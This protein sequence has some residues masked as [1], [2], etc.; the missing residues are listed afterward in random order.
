MDYLRN[1]EICGFV[2]TRREN[3]KELS[4]DIL[5][6]YKNIPAEYLS[7]LKQFKQIANKEDTVCFN[8]IED[9]NEETETDFK[10]N[11]FELM[12]LEC[13]ED[14]DEEQGIIR[15]FWNNHIPIVLSVTEYEYLA[16]CLENDRYGEIVHGLEP[17][18]EET[19]KICDNFEQLID[20]MKEPSGNQYLAN[21]V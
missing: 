19:S 14:D 15:N 4:S 18:F 8:S 12:S 16:I 21:F 9:F 11:A 1:L 10:W 3:P 20:L 13:F 5:K 2:I 17:E 6:R 7:F